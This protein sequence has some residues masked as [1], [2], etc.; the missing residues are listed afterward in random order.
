MSR[1]ECAG[2]VSFPQY[3][4][5]YHYFGAQQCHQSAWCVYAIVNSYAAEVLRFPLFLCLLGCL[6]KASSVFSVFTS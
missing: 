2:L 4:L 6:A 3:N 5:P 1:D